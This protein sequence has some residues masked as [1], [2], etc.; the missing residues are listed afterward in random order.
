VEV[1]G[2]QSRTDRVFTVPNILSMARLAGVPV[3]LWLVLSPVF[4]GPHR[5]GWAL[6]VLAVSG[7]SDYL[8]GKLAR[9]WNQV[10]K[11]GEALDP[12]ADRLY[13]FSTVIAFTLREFIPLWFA[14]LLLGRDVFLLALVPFLRRRGL[15]KLP[16]HF[17]GKA[18]TFCLLYAFPLLLLGVGDGTLPLL[19]Q[20]F[21]WAFAIWGVALYWWAGI[22]YAEQVRRVFK[23][24]PARDHD[25]A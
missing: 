2:T 22:L 16:V 3:F 11:V 23:E 25:D 7:I 21:G 15:T 4:G 6:L 24:V 9:R 13:I 10:S 17:L 1:Q 14:I 12:L 8:D 19:A 20:V 18:A 5:D